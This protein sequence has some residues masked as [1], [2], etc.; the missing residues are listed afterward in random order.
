MHVIE[1]K[2]GTFIFSLPNHVDA[3]TNIHKNIYTLY[4]SSFE[5]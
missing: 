5:K 4:Y 2:H 3:L 1:E